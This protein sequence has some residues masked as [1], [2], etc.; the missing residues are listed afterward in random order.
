[1]ESPYW[2]TVPQAKSLQQYERMKELE[3]LLHFTA[4]QVYPKRGRCENCLG[5]YV[6]WCVRTC[7]RQETYVK[8]EMR[9]LK[10]ELIRAQEVDI[11]PALCALWASAKAIIHMYINNERTNNDKEI[12]RKYRW[13]RGWGV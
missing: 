1:M 10:R 8:D 5:S 9:N 4:V 13:V 11:L 12:Q 2:I 7:H 3:Q 6:Y